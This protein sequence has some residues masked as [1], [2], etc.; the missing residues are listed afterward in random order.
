M[1]TLKVNLL[2]TS[3][4][5]QAQ[6][7]DEYL[8]KL[9]GYYSKIADSMAVPFREKGDGLQYPLQV[10]IMSGISICDEL[11]KEK[12]KTARAESLLSQAGIDSGAG[13][14]PDGL[15]GSKETERI[16]LEML[17]KLSDV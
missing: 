4:T 1:G 3:F 2:G 12:A 9:L 13:Q 11:Y 15:A 14:V 10:A 7:D 8:E 17:D 16:V 6:E 5:I